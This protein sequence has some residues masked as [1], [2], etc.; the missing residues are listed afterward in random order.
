LWV[1]PR[2][3]PEAHAE[4][5]GVAMPLI[6]E[7][8]EERGSWRWKVPAGVRDFP[9]GWDTMLEN[10]LD[11]AHFCTAHHGTLGN[12]YNDPAPY[13]FETTRPLTMEGGFAVRGDF[14]VLEF[15]P[16]C[17]VKYMPDYPG[18]PFKGSLVLATY[19]VPTKPGWVR[20][21][22]TVIHDSSRPLGGTLAERALGLFM[23]GLLPTWIGHILSS[24]VLHQ[25]AGLLYKQY[26]NLRERGYNAGYEAGA[27]AANTEAPAVTTPLYEQLV[28]TPTSVD[29]GVLLFRKWLRKHAGGGVP[30]ACE[31]ILPARGTEDIYDMWGAH[32][33][34]CKY[35]QDAYRNLELARYASLGVLGASLLAMPDASSE[36]TALVCLSAALA[37]GLH[38]FNRLFRRYEFSHADNDPWWMLL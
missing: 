26:R 28:Y 20:P 35:C 18:M 23:S 25:D 11:P 4:A 16:P 5:E 36:R 33:Q 37:A 12:R 7:V 13:A 3:G 14:G 8:R 32:T 15:Q 10:T 6:N 17:L 9:C 34:H 24:F 27:A 19:C 2:S 38:Q 31:D 1:F 30:W 21:L 22:A 29:R